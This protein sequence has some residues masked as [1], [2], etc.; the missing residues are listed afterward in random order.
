MV[1]LVV[2]GFGWGFV[3]E[4]FDFVFCVVEGLIWDLTDGKESM[5][6]F[7]VFAVEVC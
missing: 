7:C 5:R 6:F 3:W 1:A 2:E 4:G